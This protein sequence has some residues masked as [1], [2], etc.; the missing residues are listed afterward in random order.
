[1]TDVNRGVLKDCGKDGTAEGADKWNVG[2]QIDRAP[3]EQE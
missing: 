3:E 2:E 1:M